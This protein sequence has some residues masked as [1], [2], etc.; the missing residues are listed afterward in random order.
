MGVWF[1]GRILQIDWTIR[2]TNSEC[3]NKTNE[4]RTLCTIIRERKTVYFDYIMRRE[5]LKS[6]KN[7]KINDS[8]DRLRETLLTGDDQR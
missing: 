2:V 4:S 5:A 6:M 7:V 8:R 3:L 1:L